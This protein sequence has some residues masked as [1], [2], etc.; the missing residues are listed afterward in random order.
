M[1]RAGIERAGG[2]LGVGQSGCLSWVGRLAHS[3]CSGAAVW[4]AERCSV[5]SALVAASARCAEVQGGVRVGARSQS[6]PLG[7]VPRPSP[8]PE[9]PDRLFPFSITLPALSLARFQSCF[10]VSFSDRPESSPSLT[11]FSSILAPSPLPRPTHRLSL[12]RRRTSCSLPTGHYQACDHGCA[13]SRSPL[14]ALT[15]A[16]ARTS[17]RVFFL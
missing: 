5:L 6:P 9:E 1:Q 16:S 13:L 17:L 3:A 11:L 12:S 4:C 8:Q 2:R 7:A 15:T 10:C 14:A